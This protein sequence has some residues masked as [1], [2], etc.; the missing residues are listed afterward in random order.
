MK[1]I[2]HPLWF[3]TNALRKQ[4]T[5]L[6]FWALFPIKL[7]QKFF[8]SDSGQKLCSKVKKI[9]DW[10]NFQEEELELLSQPSG[11]SELQLWFMKWMI[12]HPHS[13]QRNLTDT[14]I[15]LEKYEAF[16]PGGM[17]VVWKQIRQNYISVSTMPTYVWRRCWNKRYPNWKYC[18]QH[19]LPNQP[20][21][22][23]FLTIQLTHLKSKQ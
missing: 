7:M 5:Q 18:L 6:L 11:A 2:T 20:K 12:L 10:N 14:Q 16:F 19:F 15:T 22:G 9:Y 13:H 8:S 1:S 4:P 23:S 17:K 3:E 21:R